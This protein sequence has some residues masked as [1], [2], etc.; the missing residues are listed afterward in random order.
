M[1]RQSKRNTTPVFVPDAGWQFYWNP[2]ENLFALIF[3]AVYFQPG[4]EK[5]Q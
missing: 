1:P 4:R 2:G 3:P 5:E